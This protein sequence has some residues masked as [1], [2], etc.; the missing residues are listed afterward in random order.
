MIEEIHLDYSKVIYNKTMNRK[1]KHKVTLSSIVKLLRPKQWVKNCFIFVPL[2]FRGLAFDSLS[3]FNACFAFVLFCIAASAVYVLNDIYDK[4]FDQKHPVKSKERPIASGKISI[5]FAFYILGF[6]YLILLAQ[7]W[8][9][10]ELFK[11]LLIY[12]LLNFAYTFVFKHQ[13]VI[14][15][16]I[17]AVGFVL[18]VVAGAVAI[19]VQTSSWM[20]ITTLC[21]ALYMAAIKRRQE[22]LV[23]NIYSEK[24]GKHKK[25]RHVLEKY[26][27]SLLNRYAEISGVSAFIFYSMYVFI[28][29]P[30]LI[31]SIPF[32]IFGL[33]RYWFVVEN[34]YG[35]ESPTDLVLSDWQLMLSIICWVA[36]CSYVMF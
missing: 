32:V 11:V 22:I 36:V 28:K 12:I 4:E 20:L 24:S 15:I 16:F 2:I 6:L 29:Q 18:R 31:L 23:H 17:I 7:V 33:F 30:D 9:F 1:N 21:L 10:P 8:F 19:A 3:F 27:R 25:T 35:G 26:N 14:D 13:P 34:Q 5:R